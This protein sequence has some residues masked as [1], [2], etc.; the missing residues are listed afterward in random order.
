M[1]IS[2]GVIK[3][4]V[5]QHREEFLLTIILS[6]TII[7]DEGNLPCNVSVDNICMQF[8]RFHACQLIIW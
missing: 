8:L 4:T 7:E 3:K 2:K 6:D 5:L 1:R